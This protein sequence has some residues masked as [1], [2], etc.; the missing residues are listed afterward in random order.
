MCVLGSSSYTSPI[1]QTVA[2]R[3]APENDLRSRRCLE[4]NVRRSRAV[5][6]R[7][8]DATIATF[9]TPGTRCARNTSSALATRS[10]HCNANQYRADPP[11]KRTE[12]T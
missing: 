11:S 4:Q 2:V 12:F 6:Q 1:R 3:V 8:R 10:D 7:E 9:K 5:A